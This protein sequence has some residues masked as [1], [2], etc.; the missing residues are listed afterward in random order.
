M[1]LIFT[2]LLLF[3]VAYGQI[4]KLP[5]PLHDTTYNSTIT[6]TATYIYDTVYWQADSATTS[7]YT[8]ADTAMVKYWHGAMVTT[9]TVLFF[10]KVKQLIVP[11]WYALHSATLTALQL[12]GKFI[13]Q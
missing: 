8:T 9:R 5:V 12:K 3:S 2:I 13:T 4:T 11:N 10:F 7:N 1:K 6:D